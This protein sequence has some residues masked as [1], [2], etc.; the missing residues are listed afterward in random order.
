[1]SKKAEYGKMLG[2][3]ILVLVALAGIGFGTYVYQGDFSSSTGDFTRSDSSDDGLVGYWSFDEGSAVDYSGN[4]NDGTVIGAT[5]TSDG[6]RNGGMSFDGVS[7]Y[8]DCGNDSSLNINGEI[9]IE[10]WIKP[11]SSIMYYARILEK[12]EYGAG[13]YILMQHN[14]IVRMYLGS[15][16]GWS[17]YFGAMIVQQ[18]EWHHIVYTINIAENTSNSYLN[19]K[20]IETTYPLPDYYSNANNFILGSDVT[21]YIYNGSIDEVRIYNRSLSADE[22]YE[23]YK[24]K[25]GIYLDKTTRTEPYSCDENT[26]ALWHFDGS[27]SDT[28]GTND[29]ILYGDASYGNGK[30]DS[31]GLELDGIGDY[32]DVSDSD[33]WDFGGEDFTIDVWFRPT[34]ETHRGA[35]ITQYDD[36]YNRWYLKY[37]MPSGKVEFFG[38]DTDI[39]C[40]Y[41][42]SAEQNLIVDNW[43]HLAIVRDGTTATLYLDGTSV[44][45]Y[46]ASTKIMPNLASAVWIGEDVNI[47]YTHYVNG[48]IDELRITKGYARTQEE[49]MEH[50]HQGLYKHQPIYNSE[51]QLWQNISWSESLPASHYPMDDSMVG[52]WKFEGNAKDASGNGN[53]GT[54][55]GATLTEGG[56]VGKAYLFDGD[57]VDIGN[58]AN[59]DFERTDKFSVEAWIKPAAGTIA[60]GSW[61]IVAK[62]DT[63]SPY[64][65]YLLFNSDGK[66]G[67]CMYPSSGSPNDRIY[68]D[69]NKNLVADVWQHVAMSYDGS[70]SA[71]GV[72]LYING[73]EEPVTVHYDAL[74]T[75][76]L[77]NINVNIGARNSGSSQFNG[78]IDEVAVYKKALSE[79]E[80]KQHYESTKLYFQTRTSDDN[81]TWSKWS[82]NSPVPSAY[83]ENNTLLKLDFDRS[84]EEYSNEQQ[85]TS[86]DINK[87][88]LVGYWKLDGDARDYSGYGNDGTV[89]GAASTADG[90]V[91]GAYEF[92]GVEDYIDC[93]NDVSLDILGVITVEA[94]VKY[95]SLTGSQRIISKQYID[96]F[97]TSDSCFQLGI[98][99]GKV[100]WSVGGVFDIIEHTLL[101]GNWYH[102]VGTYDREFAKLYVNGIEVKSEEH[103][104]AIRTSNYILSIGNSYPF[105]S[106]GWLNG[107]LDEVSIY[108]RALSPSEIQQL[109]SQSSYKYGKSLSGVGINESGA[110]IYPTGASVEDDTVL[111]CRFDGS[112]VCE[113]GQKGTHTINYAG[114]SGA[115]SAWTFEG[116]A[117]DVVGANHGTVYGATLANGWSGQAYEFDGVDDYIDLGDKF[118]GY[119]AM[120]ISVWFNTNDISASRRIAAKWG[121]SGQASWLVEKDGE[122][123]FI[124]FRNSNGVVNSST[125]TTILEKGKWYHVVGTY[126]GNNVRAYLNGILKETTPLTGTIYDST[127]SARIGAEDRAG[128]NFNGSI[129]QVAIYNR[130]LTADEVKA[131]YGF[132]KAKYDKG[133]YFDGNSYV[134]LPDSDDWDFGS[135]DFTI[136][137]WVYLTTNRPSGRYG[138]AGQVFGGDRWRLSIYPQTASTNP[139]FTVIKNSITEVNLIS[140]DAL[141]LNTWHY[142][143]VTRTNNEWKLY[144]NN[145]ERTS[146]ISSVDVPNIASNLFIGEESS[147]L[148]DLMNGT[149]DELRIIKGRALTP[150]E[151]QQTYLGNINA[152]SGTISFYIK[153]SW[154]GNDNAEHT[155]FDEGNFK[156]YKD[157]SNNLVFNILG[158]EISIPVSSWSADAWHHIGAT[159]DSNM[160]LTIDGVQKNSTAAPNVENLTSFMFL[161][162]AKD[163]SSAC[164]CIIDDFNIFN[165][166]KP[167]GEIQPKGYANSGESISA[168]SSKYIQWRSILTAT[169][170]SPSFSSVTIESINANTAPTVTSLTQSPTELNRGGTITI[171]CD[172]TDDYTTEADLTATMQYQLPGDTG[173][174]NL[175][176]TYNGTSWVASI[177]ITNNNNQLGTWDFSCKLADP[178]L[179]SNTEVD[180]DTV[181]VNN[182]IPTIDSITATPDPVK[183]GSTVTIT[184]GT[185]ADT[186]SETLN[187][188]CA[189]DNPHPDLSNYNCTASSSFPYTLSCTMPSPI[190]DT[191]Y[192]VYC[193]V[194]DSHDYSI[195]VSDTFTSDSTPPTI[196]FGSVAGDT[197]SPYWDIVDDSTTYID[198]DLSENN[199]NCRWSYSDIAYASMS[200]NCNSLSGTDISCN[201]GNITE[202]SSKTVYIG[203]QDGVGNIQ[204]STLS[205]TFGVDFTDPST[206]ITNLTGG[207][208]GGIHLPGYQII[209]VEDDIPIENVPTKVYTWECRDEL[210]GDCVIPSTP[211]TGNIDNGTILTFSARGTNRIK[212]YSADEAGHTQ[213]PVMDIEIKINSLPVADDI[214]YGLNS[215]TGQVGN[216]VLFYCDGTDANSGGALDSDYHARIWIKENGAVDWGTAKTMTFDGGLHNFR[217]LYSITSGY[218]TS[219]DIK[220]QIEDDYSEWGNE[221]SEENVFIVVNTAPIVDDVSLQQGV[222]KFDT[223]KIYCDGSDPDGFLSESELNATLYLRTDAAGTWDRLDGVVMLWDGVN[224]Y[225]DW[226]VSDD[227]GTE[228]DVE[229]HLTDGDATGIKQEFKFE[230]NGSYVSIIDD[231]DNDGISDSVDNIE[232]YGS[233]LDTELN[234]TILVDS[235][236]QNTSTNTHLVEFKVNG[237]TIIKFNN[238]FTENEL[239]MHDIK[240]NRTTTGKGSII[241]KGL[242]GLT[243]T[244]HVPKVL[245]IGMLCVKNAEITSIDEI[246]SGCD[247][248]DET[249]FTSCNTGGQ[250]ID[251][252]TCTDKGTYYE[253]TGL[254]HSAVTEFGTARLEVW[255]EGTYWQL[256][257][258][259][260]YANYTNS[261]SGEAITGADCDIWFADNGWDDMAFDGT[262][263]N[264]NRT[265]SSAGDRTYNVSCNH[266][267]YTN[268][269]VEDSFTISQSA[270]PEFSILTLVLGLAVVLIGLYI[271]RRKN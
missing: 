39:I 141:E 232:G 29:G 107:T 19:G 86:T 186:E 159:W 22:V 146:T 110:A 93:G 192:T 109:Y 128:Y 191:T 31:K 171:S 150:E 153:S 77:T 267:D 250:T 229:C 156:I 139:F 187:L 53:D 264:Y 223:M 38:T 226:I 257:D 130:A 66:L 195:A 260:F 33:D 230:E 207:I 162:N 188:Y 184:T 45:T 209:M 157:V 36:T 10:T 196:T 40:I 101:T 263:H 179:E 183:G 2:L 28:C 122:H 176:E 239:I 54:V 243:K 4:G 7:S 30:F 32:V 143:A 233:N 49:L 14:N 163:Y 169:E 210:G 193:K 26:V 1:M 203:C 269:T 80:I 219:Y 231:W 240:I 244:L 17:G 194:Y 9:T 113:Q 127:V 76:I 237:E 160:I 103:T 92:D 78:T 3:G 64:T 245:G 13:G 133:A 48:S 16:S 248:V 43:Y 56:K 84:M 47:G 220:C 172:G 132:Q 214:S 123:V 149:I 222:A 142:L 255:S 225:Y 27:V 198:V 62:A 95:A 50:Y 261:S 135:G 242:S 152:S 227:G 215:Y 100:R 268:L 164:D 236:E 57:Y 126:D 81:S 105:Y 175:T 199:S 228:Y 213:T 217:Y 88:G 197:S 144:V 106:Y 25:V 137:G 134:S 221:Y 158:T 147:A 11:I 154:A 216:Y 206:Y 235:T 234:I 204:S 67:A 118:E 129:D 256:D 75:S 218:P 168:S 94:W 238:N 131:H 97:S 270:I 51:I 148:G 180:S 12:G 224:H 145:V 173:W 72:K 91:D 61:M 102:I 201:L 190:D 44:G 125:A 35:L 65:G 246:S 18:D 140:P 68:L 99:S 63:V 212:F 24:D 59:F 119:S 108:N 82:G 121:A 170:S 69:T 116:N 114:I 161:G 71:F 181:T 178:S 182:N 21:N 252:F 74:T 5:P 202:T 98:S 167:S 205:I 258:I 52:Y 155:F 254:T 262:F 104:T 120:T 58:E 89:V 37:H 15:P 20:L 112:N 259:F 165:Y 85:M 200:N 46:D 211:S 241:V 189:I 6:H 249:L 83:E 185:I 117:N 253:V 136:D 138:V 251:S 247:A 265:F 8:V 34:E 151:I 60:G 79:D 87:T 271:M 111:L 70:G 41:I 124:V 208:T 90:A 73:V 96:S 174:N 115:V 23:H 42:L 177:A 266:A 55:V 166:A